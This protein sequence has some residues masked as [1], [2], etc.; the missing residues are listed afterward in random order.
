MLKL[1]FIEHRLVNLDHAL[2]IH[3]DR[4]ARIHL[5]E[6]GQEHIPE[7]RH[8]RTL[9]L[10]AQLNERLVRAGARGKHDKGG[11]RDQ[12]V[13]HQSRLPGDR[14]TTELKIPSIGPQCPIV[15]S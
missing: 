14:S 7:R 12:N 4:V 2:Q 8:G 11:N 13:F 1:F 3:V 9:R 5:L 15:T 10:D 6:L